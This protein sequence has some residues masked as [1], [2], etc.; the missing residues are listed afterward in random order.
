MRSLR[1]LLLVNLGL[2]TG[3]AL[4]MVGLAAVIATA[5]SPAD[6]IWVVTGYGIGALAVILGFGAWL[7][8]RLILRPLRELARTAD[9][10]AVDGGGTAPAAAHETREFADLD[11]RFR[12]MA[13][14]L[15]DAQG[16]VVRVEKLAAIGRLS[17]GLA[18]EIRNPLGALNTYVEVLKQRGVDAEVV[19]AMQEEVGRMDRIV[20]G[21][22]DYA[23]PR[24]AVHAP[25]DLALAARAVLDFLTRQ[26]ALKGHPVEL[27]AD[28][29]APL[30]GADPHDLQQ[31]LVNLILNARDA[32]PASRIVIGVHRHAPGAPR[33]YS[34][35][36]DT[37][38][39]ARRRP[40]SPPPR[41]S[42][43]VTFQGTLLI[44]ADEGPG[45]AEADR[46]RIFDPFFTTKA[47]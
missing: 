12:A 7:V 9:A 37:G 44:V 16:Q 38:A 17:A 20:A 21:L 34:D 24:P 45:V 13:Q 27:V 18:H 30:V 32:S 29:D 43:P 15:M 33:R 11:T 3:A 36:L 5:L 26:G 31:I 41:P 39:R 23:R 14:R 2:L 35:E 19:N 1:T 28:P 40:A 10:L 22:L 6:A 4:L 25:A 42:G 8:R 47:P 46:E